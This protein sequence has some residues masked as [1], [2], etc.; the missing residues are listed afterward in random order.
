MIII[1]I[2][3]FFSSEPDCQRSAKF[4]L[5]TSTEKRG[6]GGAEIPAI[7]NLSIL[8]SMESNI[9]IPNIQTYNI[10]QLGSIYT[11]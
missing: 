9:F 2:I 1:R 4:G 10:I 8:L 3:I 7:N 6:G 11:S 5:G